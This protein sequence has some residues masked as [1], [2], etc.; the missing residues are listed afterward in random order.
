MMPTVH[1]ETAIL[2]CDTRA[3][4]KVPTKTGWILSLCLP[5][6]R[7]FTIFWHTWI[8]WRFRL[9]MVTDGEPPQGRKTAAYFLTLDHRMDAI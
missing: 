4:P 6:R 2:A 9:R 1:V 5:A 7:T 3:V 8:L